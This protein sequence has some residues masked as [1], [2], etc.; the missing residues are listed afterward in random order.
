VCVDYTIAMVDW[1]SHPSADTGSFHTPP[2]PSWAWLSGLHHPV[3]VLETHPV[4]QFV[5]QSAAFSQRWADTLVGQ[6]AVLA[7]RLKG[8]TESM[9]FEVSSTIS[10]LVHPLPEPPGAEHQH[11]FVTRW[12]VEW[13]ETLFPVTNNTASLPLPTMPLQLPP[14]PPSLINQ[15][16]IGTLIQEVTQAVN[17][18]LILDEIFEALGDVLKRHIPYEEATIALLDDTQNGVKLLVKLDSDGFA[19]LR[20]EAHPFTGNDPC[21]NTL[22]LELKA[23]TL[24]LLST[25]DSVLAAT[26]DSTALIVPLINR[27]MMIGAM[28]LNR[29]LD[30]DVSFFT[31]ADQAALLVVADPVAL[32]VENAKF[33]LQ[34]QA[35][36]GR[37]FLI[38]RLTMAIRQS[39]NIERILSTAVEELGQVMGVSRCLIQAYD[40]PVPL[41]QHSQDEHPLRKP[42]APA[43]VQ[44]YAYL[45]PGVAGLNGN[46]WPNATTPAPLEWAVFEL[47]QPDPASPDTLNPFV[48]D[49]AADCKP[50][51]WVAGELSAQDLLAQNHVASMAIFPI[52]AAQELVGTITLH[53]C[54]QVRTWLPEDLELFG[55]LAEHL[56]VA[57]SQARMVVRLEKQNT[58]LES[59]LSVLQETQMQLIQTEKMAMLGQFVAGIAHEVNTPLGTIVSNNTTLLSCV[60]R[61]LAEV[62]QWKQ[63]HGLLDEALPLS[64]QPK[65]MEAMLQ[66]LRLNRLAT[67]RI[68]ETV[69]NLRNFVRLDES[70]RKV[71]SLHEG[72]D[73][74]LLILRGSLPIN[75]KLTKQFDPNLPMVSCFAGLLNQVFMNLIVNAVHATAHRDQPHITLTTAL[76]LGTQHAVEPMNSG[77][78]ESIPG[79]W[80]EV[81]VAD[82]GSGIAPEHLPRIFDPG[83]TTKGRGVGTGLGL[84]LCYQIVEKHGGHITV[85]SV[86]GQGT[87]FC[88]RLPRIYTTI[89]LI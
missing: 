13:L 84:A 34:V 87:T 37:E 70:E 8:L 9:R 25:G 32:A 36:A 52:L 6:E 76:V 39:L 45:L 20:N 80:I 17:S 78:A 27:G 75:L 31:P 88:I 68:D 38:N 49:D 67:N 66:L 28:A 86:V 18:S 53:Q 71:V 40:T 35:Q 61:L 64:L 43:T 11:F 21:L 48:L 54:D 89:K 23:Q 55:T 74:T 22:L 73:S 85:D 69:K 82:N 26:F 4:A 81:R 24:P 63:T 59:T 83:F 46:Y 7:T 44:S 29:S 77:P 10:L 57:L 33:Y 50:G 3:G 60:E 56:G 65:R 41:G 58:Q 14:P 19:D 1:L 30:G 42:K 5:E 15:H 62:P 79:D 2:L 16:Q 12:L 72:L 47:R 51:L